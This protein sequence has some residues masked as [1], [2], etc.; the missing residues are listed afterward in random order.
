MSATKRRR[1]ESAIATIHER[2]GPQ[3]VRTGTAFRPAESI[4][5]I[6]TG[7]AALDAITGCQGA[8]LGA[9]TLLS[10]RTTSG[11]LTV[12]CKF[13]ASAQRDLRGDVAYTVAL[14]DL[15]RTADP[16]YLVRCGVDLDALLV[17]R[18]SL[19]PQAVD[20]LGDL[21]QQRQLRAVV[22]DS[23]PDWL[24]NR[25]VGQRLYASLRCLQTQ[26]RT[27]QCALLMLDDP[28]PPWRRWFY[29][30]KSGRVRWHAVLH[31][32]MRREQW[33]TKNGKLK[34]YRAQARL[35]KSKWV[36]GFPSAPVEIWFN[37]T[38]RARE[39]W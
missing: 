5:H 33:L 31:I 15:N 4:P 16:D 34:G 36:Y 11:K 7:F 32:E 2:Y 29:L 6:A 18:P 12:A 25:A 35:L 37:G 26:L 10:G 14:F 28:S 1:L 24:A 38:V 13:L 22:I 21:V 3:A 9:L 27:A 8:P 17:V 39:T 23:L 30:D 20:L 19:Q